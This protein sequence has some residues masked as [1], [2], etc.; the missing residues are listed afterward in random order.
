MT[1]MRSYIGKKDDL[2]KAVRSVLSQII[3][4]PVQ[5]QFSGKGKKIKGEA[6]KDF[7]S[8]KTYACMKGRIAF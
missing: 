1:I 8:T 6:K 7:S 4:Q 3:A 5:L 2:S